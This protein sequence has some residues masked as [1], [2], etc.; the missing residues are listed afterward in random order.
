MLFQRTFKFITDDIET[1][2]DDSDRKNSVEESS[3]EE[4]L[5]YKLKKKTRTS[6]I[7]N[8][9]LMSEQIIT[10]VLVKIFWKISR[11]ASFS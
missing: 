6:L 8:S 9:L 2:S 11:F 5:I 1:S 3:N 4:N 10:P 7:F